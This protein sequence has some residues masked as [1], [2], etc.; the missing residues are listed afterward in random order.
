MEEI[1]LEWFMTAA[2]FRID[3]QC[4]RIR[5]TLSARYV[6]NGQHRKAVF[7]LLACPPI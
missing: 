1:A 4:V 5:R 6:K 3:S 2:A 7:R